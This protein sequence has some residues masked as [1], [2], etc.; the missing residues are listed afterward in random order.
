MAKTDQAIV[1]GIACY[2]DPEFGDLDSPEHDA[3]A[4]YDWL[5]ASAGGD[6]PAANVESI[7]SSKFNPSFASV[8]DALPSLG[9]VQRALDRLHDRAVKSSKAGNGLKIGRR[10]RMV[11]RTPEERKNIPAE[12]SALLKSALTEATIQALVETL[13]LPRGNVE[14]TIEKLKQKDEVDAGT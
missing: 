1:V 5:I 2:P 13:R 6:V 14:K 7:V 9:E 8:S 3:K 11:S 12:D 10:L 4:F